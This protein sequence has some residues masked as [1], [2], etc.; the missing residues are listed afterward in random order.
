MELLTG[1][2]APTRSLVQGGWGKFLRICLE[3][4]CTEMGVLGCLGGG[5]G[6]K[7]ASYSFPSG[8]G[9]GGGVSRPLGKRRKSEPESLRRRQKGKVEELE[10]PTAAHSQHGSPEQ[11]ALQ[12]QGQGSPWG[13]PVGCENQRSSHGLSAFSYRPQCLHHPPALTRATKAAAATTS[14]P[15]TP[16]VCPGQCL[17]RICPSHSLL[18][19]L[20]P[21]TLFPPSLLDSCPKE[22]CRAKARR[23]ASGSM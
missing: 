23:R 21:A 5:W 13:K 2:G 6:D 12:V 11:R 9:P 15:Q 10:P 19:T 3:G 16:A 17:V 8:Q 7:E 1:D 22:T 4:T 18:Q 20:S 14:V